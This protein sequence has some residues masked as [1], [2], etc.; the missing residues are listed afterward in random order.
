[1][2]SAQFA[3]LILSLSGELYADPDLVLEAIREDEEI[4][5]LARDYARG[6]GEYSVILERV[7][8]LI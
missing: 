7:T 1:M 6:K 4:L 5:N 3:Q 8:A 2:S